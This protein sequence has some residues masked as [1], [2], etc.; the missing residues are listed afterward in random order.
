MSTGFEDWTEEAIKKY[1]ARIN[2]NG[3]KNNQNIQ[4]DKYRWNGFGHRRFV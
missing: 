2:K 4:Y 1:Y 3:V